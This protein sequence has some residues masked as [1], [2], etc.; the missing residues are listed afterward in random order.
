MAVTAIAT[1]G[2]RLIRPLRRVFGL[3]ERLLYCAF[4]AWLLVAATDPV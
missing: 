2:T 4:L 1:L 3:V